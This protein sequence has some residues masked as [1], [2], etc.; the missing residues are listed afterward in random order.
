MAYESRLCRWQVHEHWQDGHIPSPSGNETGLPRNNLGV[1]AELPQHLAAA[2]ELPSS[3]FARHK[4]L[5]ICRVNSKMHCPFK[6]NNLPS[7]T[8]ISPGSRTSSPPAL[9]QHRHE[10]DF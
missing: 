7:K 1:L 5:S 10:V 9:W 6:M 3:P 4:L 8:S 2:G